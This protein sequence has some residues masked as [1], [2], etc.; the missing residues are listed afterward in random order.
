MAVQ[1]SIRAYEQIAA[2]LR[3]LIRVELA[4]GNL[5][6]GEHALAARYSVHRM[7]VRQALD[8]IAREGLI[9]R[10][11]G[12]GSVVVDQ[13]ATGECAI[14]IRPELLD[15][16]RFPFY[17][18]VCKALV[19]AVGAA[20]PSWSV[21]MH[22]GKETASGRTFPETL[23]LLE[24]RILPHLRGVYSF[25]PLFELEDKLLAAHVPVVSVAENGQYTVFVARD[26]LFKEGLAHLKS[27]GCRTLGV[28]WA[29]SKGRDWREDLYATWMARWLDAGAL[30][31]H[32]EWVEPFPCEAITERAGYESFLRLWQGASR[33]EGILVADDIMCRGVLRAALHLGIELP[34]D[35][36]LVTHANRGVEFPYHKPVTRVEFDPAEL[37][38]RA[39]KLM[40]QLQEGR[41]PARCR[42]RLAGK[43]V[44]GETT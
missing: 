9:D 33:P 8:V 32:P 11:Q 26:T 21:R 27:V 16:G 44:V 10:Q 41:K 40:G 1:A 13:A 43:L 25:H 19:D 14:A 28:I 39:V 2:D 4:P 15:Q 29:L 24:P 20:N 30:D 6:P 18:M 12:K 23:D 5:L 3:K 36:R 31:S 34:R 7:T 38:R 37:V 22:M 17:G 35:L 42:L